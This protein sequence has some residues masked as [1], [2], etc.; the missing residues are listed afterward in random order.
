[1]LL[2]GVP[3]VVA[4][5]DLPRLGTFENPEL[6]DPPGDVMYDDT[7]VG[8]RPIESIDVLRGWVSYDAAR[9]NLSFTFH[10]VDTTDWGRATMYDQECDYGANLTV[11][12]QPNGRLII[13]WTRPANQPAMTVRVVHEERDFANVVERRDLPHAWAM[14]HAKPGNFTV[15]MER[16]T[17]VS[18]AT[19]IEHPAISCTQLALIPT[20][21][22]GV[23]GSDTARSD[24]AYAMPQVLVKG[25]EPSEEVGGTG[26]EPAATTTSGSAGFVLPL[27]IIA[28]A[29]VVYLR[30]T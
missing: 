5:S 21:S 12:G 24:T 27:A 26:V 17:L 16:A 7:Y 11:D 1:M 19:L 29:L 8:P 25:S 9:D 23:G 10:F 13:E 22:I 18:L 30:R 14:Q 28:L 4:A 3:G 2:L 20:T 6:V 15:S